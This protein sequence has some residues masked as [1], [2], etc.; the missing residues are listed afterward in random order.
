MV[1]AVPCEVDLSHLTGVTHVDS[2][3]GVDLDYLDGLVA[4]VVGDR[5]LGLDTAGR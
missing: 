3:T 2:L 4:S 1:V 5:P